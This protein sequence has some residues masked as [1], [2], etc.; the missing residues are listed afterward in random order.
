MHSWTLTCTR[1]TFLKSLSNICLNLCC[2]DSP[3]YCH[4]YVYPPK[5]AFFGDP[6]HIQRHFWK[7]LC[8]LIVFSKKLCSCVNPPRMHYF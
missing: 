4:A 2:L 8:C 3:Y 6:T 5:D 7:N 1:V